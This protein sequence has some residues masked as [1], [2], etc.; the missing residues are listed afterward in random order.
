MVNGIERPLDLLNAVK[1]KEILVQ[2][3]TG[4]QLVG[5]YLA[6][7]IRINVVLDNAKDVEMENRQEITA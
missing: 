1:G 6:F 5:T 7:D 3:K 4:K 2:L